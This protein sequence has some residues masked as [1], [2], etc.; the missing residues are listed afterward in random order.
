MRSKD[1]GLTAKQVYV[2]E[3]EIRRVSALVER[4][5]AKRM[6]LV[7]AKIGWEGKKTQQTHITELFHNLHKAMK[8]A[9]EQKNAHILNLYKVRFGDTTRPNEWITTNQR[10]VLSLQTAHDTILELSKFLLLSPK[11]DKPL[12]SFS[13]VV[14]AETEHVHNLCLALPSLDRI[15][16][17]DNLRQDEKTEAGAFLVKLNSYRNSLIGLD[18]ESVTTLEQLLAYYSREE[19]FMSQQTWASLVDDY[20]T[21][22]KSVFMRAQGVNLNAQ[23]TDWFVNP[24]HW[25]L[26][27]PVDLCTDNFEKPDRRIKKVMQLINGM[28]KSEVRDNILAKLQEGVDRLLGQRLILTMIEAALPGP[29]DAICAE[30]RMKMVLGLLACTGNNAKLFMPEWMQNNP[31][32]LMGCQEMLLLIARPKQLS[33]STDGGHILKGL[34]HVRLDEIITG[35]LFDRELQALL[36]SINPNITTEHTKPSIVQAYAK[37]IVFLSKEKLKLNPTP[38]RPLT[39]FH[40]FPGFAQSNAAIDQAR[41]MAEWLLFYV[42]DNDLERD[43]SVQTQLQIVADCITRMELPPAPPAPTRASIVNMAY[44][45]TQTLYRDRNVSEVMA[46]LA[47]PSQLLA[48]RIKAH[49]P[50]I[51]KFFGSLGHT[52]T[53]MRQ[54]DSSAKASLGHVSS[55]DQLSERGTQAVRHGSPDGSSGG[56]AEQMHGSRSLTPPESDVVVSTVPYADNRMVITA[57]APP[58][59]PP[60]MPTKAQLDAAFRQVPPAKKALLQAGNKKPANPNPVV[61]IN[62]TNTEKSELEKRVALRAVGGGLKHVEKGL[63]HAAS[64][65]EKPV[66]SMDDIKAGLKK[67]RGLLSESTDEDS[68]NEYSDS[69][70][71][72]AANP[73]KKE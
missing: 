3:D 52:F 42:F 39:G 31:S 21:K 58:P 13:G 64:T 23:P 7:K 17:S 25:H 57:A 71:P 29:V 46:L 36:E 38:H 60:P 63:A 66:D 73:G 15:T 14:N 40:L 1:E 47:R 50:D 18:I 45:S 19:Y 62:P 20:E 56:S 5:M 34:R 44:C 51:E 65:G 8:P 4:E 35:N 55:S 53:G 30:R 6:S 28:E 33:W 54:V 10:E 24:F 43:S 69:G 70:T 59:P 67:F 41:E 2:I 72:G 37:L 26:D 49:N 68:D 12:N 61:I 32:F 9:I 48:T 16:K 22:I 11:E 27:G